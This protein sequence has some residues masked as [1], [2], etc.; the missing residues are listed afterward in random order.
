CSS[1]L[2]RA[3][4]LSHPTSLA[5]V[6]SGQDAPIL[7]QRQP[8]GWHC[9]ASGLICAEQSSPS[10]VLNPE[11]FPTP[12]VPPMLVSIEL[13]FPVGVGAPH[14]VR[15]NSN[16]LNRANPTCDPRSPPSFLSLSSCANWRLAKQ[17]ASQERQLSLSALQCQCR[18]CVLYICTCVH[19]RLLQGMC[20]TMVMVVLL[21]TRR[22]SDS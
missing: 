2:H 21:V 13:N 12:V 4:L 20:R 6:F 9:L 17:A 14:P 11:W 8:W 16:Q 5:V 3:S 10:P 7:L 22:K 15:L 19:N 1:M 18:L